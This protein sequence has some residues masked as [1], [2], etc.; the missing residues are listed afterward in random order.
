MGIRFGI[1]GLPN[2]GKSTIFNA[3]T[4]AHAEVAN[5]PFTTIQFNKGIVSVP[6]VRLK[7]LS[8]Y[9]KGDDYIFV[10]NET[11]EQL[12]KTAFYRE[13]KAMLKETGLDKGKKNIVYYCLRHT[14]ATFELYKGADIFNYR[15]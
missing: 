15:A 11:G 9:T 10:D 7:K 2:V 4:K 8:N 14:Y 12:N 1:I 6:D 13:W 5:Y 3:L